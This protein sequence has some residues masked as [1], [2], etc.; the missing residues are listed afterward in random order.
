LGI[1]IGD[2]AIVAGTLY[3]QM[4]KPPEARVRFGYARR[5]ASELE[6]EALIGLTC[7]YESVALTEIEHP[8]PLG[9][10][11]AALELLNGI[12][13]ASSKVPAS[14]RTRVAVKQA[15][16][17]ALLNRPGDCAKAL[18]RAHD[19]LGGIEHDDDRSG[20]FSN[21]WTEARMSF[22]EGCCALLLGD[23]RSAVTLL[24][25]AVAGI[26]ESALLGLNVARVDLGAAYVE[27]GEVEEGCRHLEEV[28]ADAQSIGH[29]SGVQRVRCVR[30][31]MNEKWGTHPSVRELDRKLA[32]IN[33]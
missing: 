10:S 20:M 14:T 26:D 2:T 24:N 3:N 12:S 5:L 25:R 23:A 22:Y 29:V 6:D 28:F 21:Y 31:R 8:K 18:R 13:T 15:E 27:A 9:N 17:Y 1:L 33:L 4:G 19:L 30:E 32:Y 11:Q 7:V 16:E